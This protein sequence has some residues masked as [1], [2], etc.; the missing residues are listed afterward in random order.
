MP[1]NR[2]GRWYGRSK[3]GNKRYSYR[4][5]YSYKKKTRKNWGP[6]AVRRKNALSTFYK[7]LN[8]AFP[9]KPGAEFMAPEPNHTV[10]GVGAY[11]M[12]S[13]SSMGSRIGAWLGDKAGSV[14]G[15]ITGLGSYTAADGTIPEGLDPPKVVNSSSGEVVISHREYIGDIIS[16][17][18]A[19]AFKK[20]TF[21]LNPGNPNCFP[22][23][24]SVANMF[25][26]YKWNGMIFEYR[27]MSVDAL[28]S[29]NTSLGQ[30]IQATQYNPREPDF[31]NKYEMENT[32]YS[33]SVKPSCSQMHPIEC[34]RS[35]TPLNNLYISPG[36]IIPE[37]DSPQ[38]Y[39][40]AKYTIATNGLQAANV[41]VGELWVT[42]EVCLLKPIYRGPGALDSAAGFAEMGL[43]QAVPGWTNPTQPFGPSMT[44]IQ[45]YI[46]KNPRNTLPID[47]SDSGA[48]KGVDRFTIT[49]LPESGGTYAIFIEWLK[50]SSTQYGVTI[51]PPDI[52]GG[53]EILVDVVAPSPV[54]GAANAQQ[55][56]AWYGVVSIAPN[57]SDHLQITFT[58]TT[59]VPINTTDGPRVTIYVTEV[60]P[61]LVSF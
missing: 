5:K 25:Q 28:N 60:P 38:F 59:S 57:V 27:T 32:Q 10:S 3:F 14:I 55:S 21:L 50:V 24:S 53:S 36:G 6:Y 45:P 35:Q 23:L 13:G 12:H 43:I 26:E 44:V 37:G 20:T 41:N 61:H 22:W 31:D 47:F 42:Y 4:N 48:G 39:D 40:F 46:V 8:Q 58:G 2:Y 7:N 49:G 34:A 52:Q 30:V 29:T 33:V 56:M 16:S 17:S 18:T 54:V 15:S 11:R 1:Y 51:Q 19:G 9:V